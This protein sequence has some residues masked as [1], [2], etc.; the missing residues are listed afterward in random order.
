MV[1]KQR[2]RTKELRFIQEVKTSLNPKDLYYKNI[3]ELI[4]YYFLMILAGIIM[5]FY[6][7]LY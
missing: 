2:N 4:K 1:N 7:W 3:E 5:V 6:M